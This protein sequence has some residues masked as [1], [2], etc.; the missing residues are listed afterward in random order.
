[1]IVTLVVGLW[2]RMPH[3]DGSNRDPLSAPAAIE[4]EFPVEGG[5]GPIVLETEYRVAAEDARDFYDTM[6][7]I[8]LSRKRN[9]ARDWSLAH[10]IADP[11]SWTERVRYLTWHDY[12]RQLHRPTPAERELQARATALHRGPEPIRVRRMLEGPYSSA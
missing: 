11:E 2:L 9:G 5:D 7:K 3:I 4:S 6:L 10:D 1:M 12:L 8:H